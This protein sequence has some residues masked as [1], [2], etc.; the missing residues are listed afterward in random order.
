MKALPVLLLSVLCLTVFSGCISE[1]Q[2]AENEK[3]LSTAKSNA[4][5]YIY[6]KYGFDA[7]ITNSEIERSAGWY[8]SFYSTAYIQMEYDGKDFMV[9][10]DGC[11]Q[12]SKGRDDYQ[13][14]EIAAAMERR[15]EEAAGTDLYSLHLSNRYY[16][17]GFQE[18]TDLQGYRL[19][20][21]TYFDGSN[22]EELE[23]EQ[24][25]DCVASFFGNKDISS[26]DSNAVSEIFGKNTAYIYSYKEDKP[27]EDWYNREA[28]IRDNLTYEYKCGVY[29]NEFIQ[30]RNIRNTPE[31]KNFEPKVLEYDGALY[32]SEENTPIEIGVAKASKASNWNGHG[33]K[34]AKIISDAYSIVHSGESV[35][36]VWLYIDRD[37]LPDRGTDCCVGS[38]SEER[39]YETGVLNSLKF[40]EEYMV[41]KLNV[42][43]DDDSFYW[44]IL[45]DTE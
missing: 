13:A 33:A 18:D 8:P 14:E 37:T 44:V 9:H 24:K 2:R 27:S 31:Y 32:I 34:N 12:G 17:T 4:V 28:E 21:N 10:I 43:P 7:T 25:F 20:Y 42:P 45:K 3:H 11:V 23:A 30:Y 15:I 40:N 19:M 29:L 38:Y 5:Q 26:L 36:N 41:C 16:K 22:F 1:E 35:C 6:E 39:G